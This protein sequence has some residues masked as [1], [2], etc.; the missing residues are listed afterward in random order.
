MSSLC[1]GPFTRLVQN[2]LMRLFTLGN[3]KIEVF[4][5]NFFDTVIAYNDHLKY[6]KQVLGL[7]YVV[8]TLFGYWVQGG[9]PK[10]LVHNLSMHFLTLDSSK[11]EVLETHFFDIVIT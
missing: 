1:T 4:G 10:G 2:L 5:T 9:V 3:S 8:L 7:I 6:T 11:I